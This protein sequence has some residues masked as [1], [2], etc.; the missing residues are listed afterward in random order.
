MRCFF[1][2]V[3]VV[4][5]HGESTDCY[6]AVDM[7]PST[8]NCY[9]ATEMTPSINGLVMC[10]YTRHTTCNASQGI[11]VARSIMRRLYIDEIVSSV[12]KILLY[13]PRA[14]WQPISLTHKAPELARYGRI[15]LLQE[16]DT[17]GLKAAGFKRGY[18][19]RGVSMKHFEHFGTATTTLGHFQDSI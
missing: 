4:A 13:T 7:A 6:V 12:R 1:P 18:P 19:L 17:L 16:P 3:N 8:S 11:T 2:L 14:S 9:V 10:L 15:A 5:C